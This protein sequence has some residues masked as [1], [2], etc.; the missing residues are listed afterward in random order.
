MKRGRDELNDTRGETIEKEN[1]E[2]VG[3][4]REGELT[5]VFG[6]MTRLLACSTYL[7]CFALLCLHVLF[8]FSVDIPVR[9]YCSYSSERDENV[10]II[11]TQNSILVFVQ[12]ISCFQ[13]K[14]AMYFTNIS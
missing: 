13:D 2:R 4:R 7:L 14:C 1:M 3:K 8:C 5:P 12:I 11:A 10:I 9:C 6:N